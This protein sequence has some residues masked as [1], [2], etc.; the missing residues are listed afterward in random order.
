MSAE[1][2]AV[3]GLVVGGLVALAATPLAIAVA[4]RTDFLDHPREYRRHAR[5]TPFLGGSAV[6]LAFAVA[7]V[8][9]G[10]VSRFWVVL[11]CA[12]AMWALG[13]VD[14]R[15]AVPPKWRL[16]AESLA[17]GCLFADHLGWRVLGNPVL[18]LALTVVW[19]TGVIN[20]FNLMDNLDGA[21][22]TV[23]CLSA[24]GIAG[25]DVLHGHPA[26][27]GLACGLAGACAGFLRYNLT[28]PSRIFLGD[29][30]SM[31][32]GFLV[33]ALGIITGRSL[34]IGLPALPAIALTAG[35]VI[36]DT[37]LV[38]V[39]RTR[40]GVSLATG[41]RD[42]LTHRLLGR[43]GSA[44]A[45]AATLA[46]VQGTLCA[47]AVGAVALGAGAVVVL[48]SVTVSLGLSVIW[49]LDTPAW[50][51]AGVAAKAPAAAGHAPSGPDLGLAPA[52][53][54]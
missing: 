31:P 10:G 8:A 21:C 48:A 35:V 4:V 54:P 43:L 46:L 49:M 11:V 13:T 14:D 15:Y 5:A 50:R 12:V 26:E 32:V 2:A 44:R 45:V 9:V 37:T 42:H 29:G 41:G 3:L 51:G 38:S 52:E 17:A 36:L 24:L 30:G 34:P 20:A 7:A 23:G 16:L 6:L 53:A 1:F 33:A 28:S 18:D 40:R 27:A 22:G 25:L 39:S 47:L 19:F